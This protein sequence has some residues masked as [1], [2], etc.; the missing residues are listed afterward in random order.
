[1]L[2]F[3]K[4]ELN[5]NQFCASSYVDWPSL[6]LA[7]AWS[8]KTRVLTYKIAYLMLEKNI[9]PDNILAVTFTN[10]A[11]T[12]MKNRLI[13]IYSDFVWIKNKISFKWVG[14]FHSI[15]TRV[16]KEDISK[17]NL[18]YTSNFSI[19]DASDSQ[20]MIKSIISENKIFD[21]IEPK[22]AK[23]MISNLKN[24]GITYQNFA[25]NI[26]D[27]KDHHISKIYEKYQ[28]ELQKSNILDFDD[29]LMLPYLIFKLDENILNKWKNRFKYILIDEAQDTNFI[30]FE[31]IRLL[32]WNNWNVTFIWDDFQSIYWWRGAMMENFLNIWKYWTDLK[33]FKLE[34][35]YRSTSTIVEVWNNIIKNNKKQ[36]NKTIVSNRKSE[37]KIILIN[38]WDESSEA[39]NIISII[40]SIKNKKSCS[41]SEFAILYRANALSQPFEQVLLT[42]SIPYKIWWWFKFFER[43]EIKDIVSYLKYFI[44]NKDSVCLKRIINIPPRKIWNTTFDK[45]QQ[46]AL[47]NWISLHDVIWNIEN[48]NINIWQSIRN[49]INNFK[50]SLKF[51]FNQIDSLKVDQIIKRLVD[52]IK[53]KDYLISLDWKEK[54]EER[55]EN[56]WQL[57]NMSTKI[58]EIWSIWLKQFIDE[59]SILTDANEQDQEN[60]ESIKLMTIHASKWLE[61]S[62]VFIVWL[63]DD[64]FPLTKAKF[65]DFEMEEERRLMYVAVTRAKDHLFLSW[66]NSRQKWWVTKYNEPS[67]FIDEIPENYISNFDFSKIE[68]QKINNSFESW[69]IVSHNLFWVWKIIEVYSDNAI[70]K[71]DNTK[72]WFRKVDLRFLKK[73]W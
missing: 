7:W 4:N 31:L 53:Y 27:E 29:L 67:C 37:D 57:I 50:L 33:T 64:T 56:I 58:E 25:N 34:T 42:E 51:I 69:D 70:V 12:E 63:E 43:K 10:K 11:A 26:W 20:S 59:I 61:F 60:S 35:N 28:K 62:N 13:S 54:A 2:D 3:F 52:N 45:L 21:R 15:F 68:N 30:Q 14:T 19:N 49:N 36:Y 24:K 16:L 73:V 9:S 46:Y 72:L 6:I 38:S 1:M 22:E 48:V 17:L 32:S 39:T 40:K 65:N 41:W 47:E 5:E 18:E 44:N 23:Y 8:W 55:F 71:F 66:A